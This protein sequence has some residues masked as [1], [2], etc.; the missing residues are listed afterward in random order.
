[1]IA[2]F[3]V[4]SPHTFIVDLIL[5]E[6]LFFSLEIVALHMVT[7]YKPQTM[8]VN[9]EPVLEPSLNLTLTQHPCDEDPESRKV[10]T[11][12]EVNPPRA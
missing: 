11:R 9:E 5:V 12:F 7:S 2:H 6:D 3:N 10:R 8:Q 1:M 4:T